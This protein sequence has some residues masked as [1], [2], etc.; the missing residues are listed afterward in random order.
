MST[1][2]CPYCHHQIEASQFDSHL[3]YHQ[4]LLADGQQRDYVTLPPE[5]RT[6]GELVGVPVVYIHEV[7]GTGTL[8]PE[9]IVRSYL[10]NPFLYGANTTFCA[11]CSKQVP[12]RECHWDETR[13]NLQDYFDRLRNAHSYVP[14][15]SKPVTPRLK[16]ERT[17]AEPTNSSFSGW[18]ILVGLAVILGGYA[19]KKLPVE[20]MK[21]V[22]NNEAARKQQQQADKATKEMNAKFRE[23]IRKGEDVPDAFLILA[24]INPEEYKSKQADL[25]ALAK[26]SAAKQLEAAGEFSKALEKADELIAESP[27]LAPLHNYKAWLL[28]TCKVDSVRNGKQAVEHALRACELDDSPEYI[29]T[30]AAAYAEDG[31]FEAA[32]EEMEQA[33]ELTQDRAQKLRFE[34]RRSL[35]Q[36]RQPYRD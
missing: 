32:V 18:T 12:N 4:E 22:G 2:P 35:Y 14:A 36:D 17:E 26:L 29:D 3:L 20:A 31:N 1:K 13:E 16:P 23:Q 7:C 33:I 25:Q 9:E 10:K 11:G 28:A 30:L 19:L 5:Q 8:M 34:A 27:D 6:E 15:E 21:Q 24:G